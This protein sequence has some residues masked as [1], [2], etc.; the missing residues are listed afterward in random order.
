[1]SALCE[2][3]ERH[4]GYFHGD[5]ERVVASYAALGDEA[6][7]P[8][9]CLL[10]H[11]RQ[12]AG[13]AAWNATH[14]SFQYVCDPF[15][16]NAA[17]SWT[18]VWSLT[19]QRH[20]LLPTGLLYFDVP[21]E[22]GGGVAFGRLQ[23]QRGWRSLEDALLQGLLELVER[24]AVA[25]WWY[26]RTR[27]PGVDLDSFGVRWVDELRE[28]YAALHREVWVL[29][30]SSDVGIPTMAALSRRTDGPRED[31]MFGFGAHLDPQVALVRALTEMNQLMPAVVAAG[32]GGDY[33]WSDPDAVH[34]WR[35]ATWAGTA[36]PAAR[37]RGAAPH[38]RGLRPLPHRR[39][40]R[41]HHHGPAAAGRPGARRHGPRP[42]PPGRRAPRREGDRAGHARLL[43][44]LR[45][46][47][48]VR[49]TR[50]ARPA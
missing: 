10:F 48:A 27:A 23:R 39:P 32:D 2:A 19:E 9:E 8:G 36:V 11:E 12:Y 43:G 1:M 6:V 28:V 47:T 34:W 5:E 3:I 41:R 44:P 13:R 22:L 21:G 24:D 16:E 20:R 46:R 29:D 15:D 18:P 42:D 38:P 14:S 30:V 17:T 40:P 7:H 4:S 33:D 35:T 50:Q 49:R 31:I 26:N 45:P 25:L 37:S